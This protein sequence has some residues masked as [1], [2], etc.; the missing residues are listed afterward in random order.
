M[1]ASARP[2]KE[3]KGDCAAGVR[4]I[5]PVEGRPLPRMQALWLEGRDIPLVMLDGRQPFGIIRLTLM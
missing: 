3:C 5:V 4:Q 1:L 2:P